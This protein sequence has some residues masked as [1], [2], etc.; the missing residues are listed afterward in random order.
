FVRKCRTSAVHQL[1]EKKC[2]RLRAFLYLSTI[3][4]RLLAGAGIRALKCVAMTCLPDDIRHIHAEGQLS[5]MRNRQHSFFLVAHAAR[6][7]LL[8]DAAR[9]VGAA[10]ELG[11]A[12]A[13]AGGAAL[14]ACRAGFGRRELM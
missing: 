9:A 14:A 2:P 10:A 11:G 12:I 7:F 8:L 6:F 4:Y 1:H 3:S 5:P 13:V